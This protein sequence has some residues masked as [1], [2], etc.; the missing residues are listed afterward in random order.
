MYKMLSVCLALTISLNATEVK[1]NNQSK[2][3]PPV[4]LKKAKTFE[5]TLIN[6]QSSIKSNKTKTITSE[7]L[8]SVGSLEVLNKLEG[9]NI[10]HKK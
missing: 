3:N 1:T 4:E 9:L 2:T 8:N 7:K 5:N 6:V 10:K